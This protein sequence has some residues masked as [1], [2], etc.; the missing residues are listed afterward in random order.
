M[1]AATR[2]PLADRWQLFDAGVE[3]DWDELRASCAP[4]IVFEDRQGF[5]H[6]RAIAS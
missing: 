6:V 1:R 5:A 3:T 2:R 4:E